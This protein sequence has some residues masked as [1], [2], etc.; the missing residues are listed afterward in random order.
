MWKKLKKLLKEYNSENGTDIDMPAFF[1]IL[2]YTDEDIELV[3]RII[4]KK[5]IHR[6]MKFTSIEPKLNKYIGDRNNPEYEKY[7][8][9]L[10]EYRKYNIEHEGSCLSMK[11]FFKQEYNL[12]DEN[13]LIEAKKITKLIY[14]NN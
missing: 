7:Y 11:N 5:K 12:T 14:C 10:C 8:N 2:N 9:L 1:K 13:A 4:K 3:N 6:E